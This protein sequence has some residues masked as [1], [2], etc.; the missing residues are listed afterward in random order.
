MK[1]VPSC[2]GGSTVA[3]K[4]T[5][6]AK[7]AAAHSPQPAGASIDLARMRVFVVD[8]RLLWMIIGLACL[9]TALWT[10]RSL[11]VPF[12][13]V[14]VLTFLG[15]PVTAR[16]QRHMPR[17]VAAA[18]FVA[19]AGL[20]LVALLALV[21]P[22]LISD[23]IALFSNLP[24]LWRELMVW[25][26]VRFQVAL[27][28]SIGELS[29]QASK[30]LLEKLTPMASTSGGFLK[31]GALGL[32]KG[33]AGAAG[34]VV[35]LALVPVLAFFL[36]S[37]WPRTKETLR[38]FV[39]RAWQ[40]IAE[41]YAPRIEHTLGSLVRGQ[42]LVASMM[43]VLYLIGLSISGVP[44]ALAIATIAGAAYLI[45][46][47]SGAVCMILAVAFSLLELKGAA[48]API[49]G[50]AITCLLVQLIEGYVLTPRIVGAKIG[51]S[52]L[53][54]VLAVLFGGAGA[55]FLGVVFALPVAAVLALVLAEEAQRRG[56]LQV[57]ASP[58]PE[59]KP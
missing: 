56:G 27:P 12:L 46:F 30:D 42:L 29:S 26:E 39:P 55:G 14:G 38:V 8:T 28:T 58:N 11:L 57:T 48:L 53:A 4:T 1:L 24:T 40:R 17:A 2:A 9:A 41:H 15:A 35:Q 36:L 59:A 37:E 19:A 16:L 43:A 49:I 6:R 52:P 47:A 13:F 3:T 5:T 45:P 33:A 50:A 34:L 20:L 7:A 10:V 54:V 51:L 18:A 44:F 31:S 21:V 23:L 32:L 25:L 22:P